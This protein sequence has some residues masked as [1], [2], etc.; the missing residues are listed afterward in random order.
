MC[1]LEPLKQGITK[2]GPLVPLVFLPQG[3]ITSNL[4][5]HPSKVCPLITCQRPDK[6]DEPPVH[7]RHSV[8]MSMLL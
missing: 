7:L 5:S 6:Q 2:S 3:Q 8:S 1:D 4:Q